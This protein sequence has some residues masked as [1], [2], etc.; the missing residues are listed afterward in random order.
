MQ[1]NQKTERINNT[2]SW[3][4]WKSFQDESWLNRGGLLFLGKTQWE[5]MGVVQVDMYLS[6]W[7]R[8]HSPSTQEAR[9]VRQS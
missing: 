9:E 7:G 6:S 4:V 8:V 2:F 5:E 1:E 3:K